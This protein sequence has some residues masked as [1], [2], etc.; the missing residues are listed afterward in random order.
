MC[1]IE[2]GVSTVSVV[3]VAKD[4]EAIIGRAVESAR[5][6]EEVLVVV[7]DS[8]T[9]RTTDMARHEGAMVLEH[10]W[11][12]YAKTKQWAVDQ[13]SGSWV[14]LLDADEVIPESLA[15]EIRQVLTADDVS[16]HGFTMP[17]RNYFLGRWM[18][19]GGW[20]PD[21]VLRLFRKSHGKFTQVQVHE[22]IQVDRDIG[23]LTQ[24]L[25]H[26]TDDS[27][28]EYFDKLNRYTTLGA[29]DLAESGRRCHWWDFTLRPCWMFLRMAMFRVGVLDGWRGLLLAM[30]SAVHVMVKYAKLRSGDFEQQ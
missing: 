17:R 26:H 21:R 16:S 4:S 15:L 22:S 12:G 18:R 28:T 8:T 5:W 13:A 7:D 29:K 25:E 10:G 30:L 19:F 2:S 14:F 6:A 9:D 11:E 1:S 24:P 27:L 20:Y 23:Q 3:I